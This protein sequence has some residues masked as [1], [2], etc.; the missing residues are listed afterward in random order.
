MQNNLSHY[1]AIKMNRTIIAIVLATLMV[2][3]MAVENKLTHVQEKK[4]KEL[5]N[6]KWGHIIFELAE[7]HSLAGGALD[8]LTNAINQL[9]SDLGDRIDELDEEYNDRSLFHQSEV[10]RI[11]S[12]ISSAQI[13]VSSTTNFLENILYPEQSKLE[14]NIASNN[15]AIDENNA[16]VVK[17]TFER[18]AQHEQ[19]ELRVEE[20]NAALSAI[21]ECLDI[22][23]QVSGGNLSF[24]QGKSINKS[25]KK[26]VDTLP[27]S[28]D[29]VLI[30]ALVQLA[31]EEFADQSALLRVFEALKDVKSGIQND[32]QA[33]HD[34]EDRLQAEFEAEVASRQKENRDYTK[35]NIITTGELKVIVDRIDTKEA[36][37]AVRTQDLANSEV[38]LEAENESFEAATSAYEDI[39]A[40][41]EREQAVANDTLEIVVQSGFQGGL[42][43]RTF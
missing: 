12:D 11:G 37:L 9:V 23:N 1:S 42:A 3:T 40:E 22:I 38:E 10:T 18:E 20:A 31:T 15:D 19:Y 21:D 26:V 5:Q 35:Q 24:A 36:F 27:K 32:L 28:T 33:D 39:R 16:Y 8:D 13:S 30:K 34:E 14:F 43:T 4:M 17:L 29:E 41:L 2:S 6:E 7:L 25:M